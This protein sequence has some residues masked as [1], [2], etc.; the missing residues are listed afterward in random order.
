MTSLPPLG[1]VPAAITLFGGGSNECVGR[2]NADAQNFNRKL[3]S[4]AKSLGKR[5]PKL[6]IAV[7][8]I[9]KPTFDLI[10]KP[11]DAG[12]YELFLVAN[13]LWVSLFSRFQVGFFL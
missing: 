3:T 10:Q 13:F 6:K 7:F 5:L 8:D 4:A 1:C 11:S 12:K 2:L 9:Y